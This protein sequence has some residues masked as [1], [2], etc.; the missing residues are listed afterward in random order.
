LVKIGL[1]SLNFLYF[2]RQALALLP[3][4][5]ASASVPKQ[6]TVLEI[7]GV[8]EFEY[9]N[10]FQI[11]IYFSLFIHVMCETTKCADQWQS[12]TQHSTFTTLFC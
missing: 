5:P 12:G 4:A 11:K 8:M 10:S 9:K 6:L 3:G 1:V 7:K 2:L